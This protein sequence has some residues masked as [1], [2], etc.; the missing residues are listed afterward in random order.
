VKQFTHAYIGK[1]VPFSRN[2]Q[3]QPNPF[4]GRR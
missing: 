1:G 2:R 4:N 3:A